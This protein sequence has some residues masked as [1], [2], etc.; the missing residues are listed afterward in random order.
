[1]N[2]ATGKMSV[3]GGPNDPGMAPDEGLALMSSR[4]ITDPRFSRLFLPDQ[5]AGKPGLSHRLNPVSLYIA[6]RW[7]YHVTPLDALRAGH[8]VVTNSTG[9]SVNAKPVD[10]GPNIETDRICDLSQGVADALG[11]QTND[12]VTVEFVPA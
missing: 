6:M 8:V 7:N 2:T 10:W 5:P 3:F 4:D 9:K 1:M 11:L 12:L